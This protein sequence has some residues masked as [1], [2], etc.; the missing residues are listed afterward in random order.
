M[1]KLY[2]PI[3]EGLSQP[4]IGQHGISDLLPVD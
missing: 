1:T 3:G 4:K 2:T